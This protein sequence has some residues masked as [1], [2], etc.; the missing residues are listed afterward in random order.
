M[1]EAIKLI[2]MPVAAEDTMSKVGTVRQ[3]IIDPENGQ[4]LGF[5]VATGLFSPA[6][7]LSFMDVVFWD[8]NGLVTEHEENLVDPEEIIRIKNVLDHNI[9]L[10]EMAAET[11]SG[12]S[13]GQ[14][15]NF[16][17][18]TESGTVVKYYLADILGKKRIL[19]ADKV[20]KIDRKVI[21]CDLDGRIPTTVTET[22]IA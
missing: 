20:I 13:L 7:A 12:Q 16:L 18:D 11:E 14:I 3:I 6:Q 5:L 9:N 1:I 15:E 17:I 8:E 4:L 10:L 21:F 19:S 2:N 22:V